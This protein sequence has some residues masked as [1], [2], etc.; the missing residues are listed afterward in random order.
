[1]LAEMFASTTNHT[2]IVSSMSASECTRVF[3]DYLR[4]WTS[5]RSA[6]TSMLRSDAAAVE[7]ANAGLMDEFEGPAANCP[8]PDAPSPPRSRRDSS[9]P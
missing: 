3:S 5:E 6:G 8:F 7:R 1:M 9:L 4:P 2:A